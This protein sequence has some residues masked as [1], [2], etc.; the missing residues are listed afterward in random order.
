MAP[1]GKNLQISPPILVPFPIFNIMNLNTTL[2]ER[3][4]TFFRVKLPRIYQLRLDKGMSSISFGYFVVFYCYL[5]YHRRLHWVCLVMFMRLYDFLL[6]LFVLVV[7]FAL[8]SSFLCVLLIFWLF[9]VMFWAWGY[10][11][12]TFAT[13]CPLCFVP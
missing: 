5:F 4:Q 13:C 1:W 6:L 11:P 2:E 7:F 9:C 8:L 10:F 3:K 12:W